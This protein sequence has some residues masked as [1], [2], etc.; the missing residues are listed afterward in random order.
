MTDASGTSEVVTGAGR[1]VGTVRG[2][3]HA[4]RGVPYAAPP[5]GRRR[6]RRPRRPE[7]WTG[8]RDAS[9]A[10]P[11]LPQP[12]RTLP[13]LDHRPILGSGWNGAP[14]QLTLNVW[15]PEPSRDA[16]CP[17]LVFVHCGGFASGSPSTPLYDGSAFARAGIVCVTV[18]Y[19][20]GGEGFLAFE[21]APRNLGLH[22]V[23]CAVRWVHEQI[24]A[25]GG[26]PA[27][28]TLAGQSAGAIAVGHLLD[29]PAHGGIV[30]RAISQS[31]GVE[32]SLSVEQAERLTRAVATEL[33]V[34]PTR[35]GFSGVSTGSLVAAASRVAPADLA[36]GD[37]PW[38]GGGLMTFLPA[39]DGELVGERP[40]EGIATAGLDGLLAGFA[41]DEANL[42]LAGRPEPATASGEWSEAVAVAGGVNDDPDAALRRLAEERPAAAPRAL[43]SALVTEALF[44][45][46]TRRLL[47]AHAS[48][49][50]R[51]Y[52]Y[53]LAW[54][55]TAVDGR[56]G[57]CHC[58]ELPAVFGTAGAPGLHGPTGLL[59]TGYPPGLAARIHAAWVA[60]VRT[61]DPGWARC[62]PQRQR[63]QRFDG[64][65]GLPE[66]SAP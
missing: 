48:G 33:R 64:D 15:T 39:R 46:P 18:S 55:S 42:Y 23:L 19:R 17:V 34:A 60:F 26:D 45:A 29:G 7:P 61:G 41:T 43:A 25:F 22:D 16:R 49:P 5:V 31:G 37:G 2:G 32:L 4:F 1:L 6:F 28:I 9:V 59:G 40:L 66:R 12:P 54:R 56:L 8:R 52:G 35:E 38:P 21:G 36:D 51:T 62:T 50:G 24:G 53:E 30:R 20:L 57:A 58:L 3:V 14:P 27:R 13:G 10:V 63:W 47:A 65:S 44:R 11:A